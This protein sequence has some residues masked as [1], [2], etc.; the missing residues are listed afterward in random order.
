MIAY[1][2]VTLILSVCILDIMIF[3]LICKRRKDFLQ[4]HNDNLSRVPEIGELIPFFDDGKVGIS[5]RYIA[6]IKDVIPR[7]MA[8]VSLRYAWEKQVKECYWL[9][10]TYTDY[11]IVASIPAYDRK[12]IIF[13][14]TVDGGWFSFDYAHWWTSGRLDVSGE[15]TCEVAKIHLLQKEPDKEFY[16]EFLID[17]LTQEQANEVFY[18]TLYMYSKENN[19]DI[20]ETTRTYN[21]ANE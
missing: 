5:R 12:P 4:R 20:Q 9:Y 14:R 6:K 11:F 2:I 15:L 7:W 19:N 8:S 21:T 3:K 10:D 17:P 1:C 16:D 18:K 13:C